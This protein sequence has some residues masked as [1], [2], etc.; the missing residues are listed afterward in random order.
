MHGSL[1][2]NYSAVENK[3]YQTPLGI[4]YLFTKILFMTWNLNFF[5]Q[6]PLKIKY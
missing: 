1:S 3:S 5:P 6:A 4:C 2:I